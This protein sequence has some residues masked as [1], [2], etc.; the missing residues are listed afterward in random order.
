MYQKTRNKLTLKDVA[1]KLSVTPA[2]VSKALRDSSDISLEMRAKVKAAAKELGY[3]PNLLARSL[4]NKSSKILG[5]LIPDLRISFFSEAVRG[6]YEEANKKGYETILL[7]HDEN[8]V[9]ERK[10][11]E[12]LSD[13][14]ADGILLNTTGSKSNYTLY[15]KLA[16]EG[17]KMVCWDRKIEDLDFHSVTIDDKKAAFELTSKMIKKGRKHILFLGPNTGIPVAKYRF[18]GYK[19]ALEHYGIPFDQ[20][21]IVQTFRNETDSYN[22]MLSILEN[23]TKIDG[24][25]SIGGLITYGAGKAVLDKKLSIPDDIILGEF[26]DNNIVARLGVPFLTVYQHPYE[27]GKSAVDLLIKI[28]ENKGSQDKFKDIIIESEVKQR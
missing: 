13:I 7:V 1:E 19:Q 4:I 17:I 24:I 25:V 15:Q 18:E 22:K 21:L 6:A 10:K 26:G 16:E 23:K 14:H 28:I 2:T 11:L 20:K 8:K 5:V 27:L 9:I 3:R 12:F